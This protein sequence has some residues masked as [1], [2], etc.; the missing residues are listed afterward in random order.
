MPD[1]K[2]MNSGRDIPIH[3]IQPL[4]Q[5]EDHSLY[6]FIALVVLVLFLV[7]AA[8]YFF[9]KFI[10]NRKKEN[11]RKKAYEAL[12]AVNL[13]DAKKAAYEITRLALVFKDDSSQIEQK[14][15]TLLSMLDKYKYRKTIDEA[16]DDEV[17]SYYHIFVE[18]IHP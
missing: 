18:M 4:V 9:I 17:K 2:I 10:K 16:L 5:V 8:G 15:E 12:V 13:N 14:Y 1:N 3:D 7:I 11:L 6:F